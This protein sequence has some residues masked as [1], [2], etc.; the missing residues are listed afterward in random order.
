MNKKIFFYIKNNLMAMVGFLL[1]PLSWWNDLFVNVP[2]AYAFAYA[3]GNVLRLFSEIS[4][5]S[6]I[7]LFVGGYWISNLLGMIML[8]A[9]LFNL[10][11]YEKKSGFSLKWDLIIV[12]LYS[13]FISIVIYKDFGNILSY[14]NII[15]DW[16]K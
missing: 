12:F 10:A 16:V 14:L 15:P 6:F 4:R 13:I 7:V 3:L 11:G 9:G 8:K 1:S 5:L 2:L